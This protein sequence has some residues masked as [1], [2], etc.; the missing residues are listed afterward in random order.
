MSAR[1]TLIR[2]SFAAVML[3]LLLIVLA[4]QDAPARA[5]PLSA[6]TFTVNSIDDAV[7]SPPLDSGPC[8]TLPNNGTCT[9]RAA[10]MKANHWPGG[11]ATIVFAPQLSGTPI[12]LK[13]PASGVDDET[14]GDLNI[15]QTVT[16]RG[17]GASQTIIDG[18]GSVT[19]DRVFLIGPGITVTMTGITIQDGAGGV[20]GAAGLG[21]G[22]LFNYGALRLD[23]S[24]VISN[25]AVPY[26]IIGGGGG[27][28]NYQ[29]ASL[30][31]VDST[32]VGNH[33]TG[34]YG[35]GIGGLLYTLAVFS[36]TIRNNIGYFGGGIYVIHG[37]TT[38]FNT[39]VS[40][41]A[42]SS[43]GGGLASTGGTTTVVNS[44]VSGN[45]TNASGGGIWNSCACPSVLNLFNATIAN[46]RA[47][48]QLTGSGTGGG[49]YNNNE[50]D[51]IVNLQ[52]SLLAD[53]VAS[54]F[55]VEHGYFVAPSDCSGALTSQDYNLVSWKSSDCTLTG[56]LHDQTNA[57][58]HLGPLQ[59][60]GGP[61]WTQAL[62]PGSQAIDAGRPEP[63]GCV[64]QY[65]AH[66]RTDQRGAPRP[67]NGAGETIC[68]IG[69]YELQR[70]LR[71]P[72]V[73]K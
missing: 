6:P 39:T 9:L 70:M 45:V 53:N 1:E 42:A 25:T 36:S 47:D 5:A 46:N 71:V 16:I 19:Q 27:I 56:G 73:L 10:I 32:I 22:G 12:R 64:D 17:N 60:N 65:G 4:G 48:A 55:D 50:N 67:A 52:N 63:G 29:N 2:G 59:D 43:S 54:D 35:G 57:A 24:V 38:L 11:G 15:S 8:E 49:V 28:F 20:F 18:N 30:T 26:N 69:A 13:F 44:T 51:N 66:L 61:T 14:T 58:A 31:L 21:G 34:G 23:H 68:D 41:N 62:L 3:G 40:D 72:L 33:S 7:A 37:N